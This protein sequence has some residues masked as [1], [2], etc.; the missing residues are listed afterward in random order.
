MDSIRDKVAI[1]GMGCTRFGERWEMGVGDLLIEAAH[2]AFEDA[3]IHPA[4]IQAA[5]LGTV[6]SGVTA[7]T[8][9]PL[10]L[11]YIPMTR[12]ENMCATGSEALRGAVYAV[13]AGACDIALAIGVEKL[14]DS[15]RT[16]VSGPAIVGDNPDGSSGI[17]S[18]FS[19]P[20]SFAYLGTRYFHHYGLTREHGKRLLAQIAVKNHH[21]GSLSPKA[22]FH[23]ELTVDQVVNA[24]MVA[25]P[26]GL[27][28]CCGVS[29]GAAAAIVVRADMASHFR[30]DPV[31]I[32]GL[33]ICVGARQG[34]MRQDYDYVHVEENV[35]AAQMAYQQAGIQDPRRDISCAEVHDCFTTHELILYEDLGFSPRG[36]AGEDIEAGTFSLNGSLPVN[37]DGGLKCFGHPLGASGLRMMYEIYKQL[38][39]KAGPRQIKNPRIGLA[40]NL[41]GNAGMGIASCVVLGNEK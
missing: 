14:K 22:H 10:G 37:T 40:H 36:K 24:P 11:Q 15:G 9:S 28:D 31:Y 13:A 29:D 35:R 21:N 7:L 19:A 20:A 8:L 27:Y 39:G 33:S 30:S 18:G 32:K 1:V 3:A 38:Q 41:G 17:G 2:E 34:V 4:D 6:F 26:L 16:G 23:N 25:W 12:V 5:W